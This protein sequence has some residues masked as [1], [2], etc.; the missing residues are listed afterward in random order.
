MD[1]SYNKTHGNMQDDASLSSPQSDTTTTTSPSRLWTHSDETSSSSGPAKPSIVN[2]DVPRDYSDLISLHSLSLHDDNNRVVSFCIAG[3]PAGTP[4]LFWYAG[5]CNRRIL[6]LLQEA[7]E[8]CQLRLV[9]LNRPGRGST[10][11]AN[12]EQSNEAI[13]KKEDK[14]HDK[15]QLSIRVVMAEERDQ[16]ETAAS[17]SNK[18]NDKLLSASHARIHM[19]ACLSDAIAVLDALQ[20]DKVGQLYECAGAPFALCFAQ[21]YSQR[22]LPSHIPMIGI[23]SWIQPADCNE[24]KQL[25]QFGARKC[26]V[27]MIAPLISGSMGC[28]DKSASWVPASWIGKKFVKS[29]TEKEQDVLDANWEVDEFVERFRFMQQ[30]G[31]GTV[32]ADLTCLLS[33]AKDIGLDYS[34]IRSRIVL[35]HA[36]ED[37]MAPLPAAQWLKEQLPNS[38]LI[39]VANATHEGTLFL[40]HHEIEQSLKLLRTGE[41]VPAEEEVV[42]DAPVETGVGAVDGVLVEPSEPP[43]IAPSDPPPIAPSEPPPIAPMDPP[44]IAPSESPPIAPMEPPY[45]A[46][47]EEPP[48]PPATLPPIAPSEPPPITPPEPP[49]IAPMDEEPILPNG[50]ELAPVPVVVDENENIFDAPVDGVDETALLSESAEPPCPAVLTKE[51]PVVEDDAQPESTLADEDDVAVETPDDSAEETVVAKESTTQ[52]ESTT[53]NEDEGLPNESTAAASD[54]HQ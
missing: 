47:L 37:A 17:T 36:M 3:D 39:Q 38:R 1:D 18:N 25:F 52:Q 31:G 46:P 34:A 42:D 7:A 45:V 53:T 27:W 49:P 23:G 30:E 48:I 5:G 40:L 24:T 44:P 22:L 11:P 6:L 8:Q 29:L 16:Q 35:V 21:H 43:P 10:S 14:A 12:Y 19:D 51:D 41:T 32:M 28:L 33:K 4:V 50:E 15:E 54:M 2:E 13:M 26:P 9:C 20:I